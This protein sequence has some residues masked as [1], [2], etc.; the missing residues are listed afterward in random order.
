M[1]ENIRDAKDQLVQDVRA[2]ISEAEQLMRSATSDGSE[3]ARRVRDDLEARLHGLRG[4]L[5]NIEASTVARARAVAATTDTYVHESPWQ[6]IAVAAGVGAI[7]GLLASRSF[8]G[9]DY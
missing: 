3:R 9:D 5:R 8:S 6:A 1:N 2:V 7:I 4:Q